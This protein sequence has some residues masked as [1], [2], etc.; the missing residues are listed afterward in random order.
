MDNSLE[1]W[2]RIQSFPNYEVSNFGN[3][4]NVITKKMKKKRISN[5]GYYLVHLWFRKKRKACT[6]HRLVLSAFKG[7]YPDL[8]CDHIDTNKLNNCVQNL[9]WVT[10]AQNMANHLTKSRV[11]NVFFQ[12]R[13]KFSGGK[14]PMAKG[15][16]CI[17]LKKFF[18][19][20]ETASRD[21]GIV[22][23]SISR[24]CEGKLKCAGGYHWKF[25]GGITNA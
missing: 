21:L 18:D 14:N 17:E 20:A 16:F 5:T 6:V 11:L 19:S 8:Q 15:V 12:N 23:S 22:R 25:S 1:I 24:A 13:Q 10:P 9:R 4:R 2:K 7:N 3:V